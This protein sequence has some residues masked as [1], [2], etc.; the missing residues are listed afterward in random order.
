MVDV[1][2][3]SLSGFKGDVLPATVLLPLCSA[4]YITCDVI[5][6]VICLVMLES[7]IEGRKK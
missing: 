6:T 2:Y 3:R 1:M 5:A 4:S 7:L